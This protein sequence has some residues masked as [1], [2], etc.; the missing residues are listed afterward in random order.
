[1][2]K[3][4]NIHDYLIATSRYD[5]ENYQKGIIPEDSRTPYGLLFHHAAICQAYAETFMIFMTLANIECHMVVGTTNDENYRR[6]DQ[7]KHAWNIVKIDKKYYHVDLT[8]DNPIPCIAG[9]VE[10]RYF[11]V[12]DKFMDKTHTWPKNQ[13]PLCF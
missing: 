4:K 7:D 3:E 9:R 5:Y 10:H 2:Q 11:N 13:F 12:S 1:L 8:F 6:G